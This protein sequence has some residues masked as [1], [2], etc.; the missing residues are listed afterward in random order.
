MNAWFVIHSE[1][2]MEVVAAQ[3]LAHLPK[4]GLVALYG[5]LGAGKTTFMRGLLRA[6]GY[7]GPVTSPTYTF[8]EVY[9]FDDRVIVHGDWYRCEADSRLYTTGID[10]YLDHALCCFEWP[11]RVQGEWPPFVATLHIKHIKA[12]PSGRFV[13]VQTT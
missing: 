4:T 9:D 13:W 11:D 1:H 10:Q 12:H 2:D 8:Y 7:P 5:E 6:A 3:V